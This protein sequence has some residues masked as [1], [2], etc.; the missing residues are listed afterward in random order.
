[1]QQLHEP[2]TAGRLAL[3]SFA[4]T[5]PTD[6]IATIRGRLAAGRHEVLDLVLV[7]DDLGHYQGAIELKQILQARDDSTAEATMRTDWPTVTPNTDQEHAVETASNASVAALPVIAGDGKPLGILPPRVLLDVLAHEHRE[8]VH[9]IV[10]I[11]HEREGATQALEGPPLRR[12]A[13]RL[14]WLLVGLAM[15]AAAVGTMAGFEHVLKANV[16]I[17]FFIPALVYLTDAVGTQTEAIAVR[18]LSL[19][20]I[21][22]GRVLSMEVMTGG[23]IGMALGIIAVVGLWLVFGDLILAIGVGI[24]LFFAATVAS[25]VGLILPWSLSRLDVDP[26]FGSGPVATIV[27]DVLTILIY[28]IVM[29]ALLPAGTG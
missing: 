18:G 23:L 6:T 19:R 15:S 1:V 8:D 16:T 28:F 3:R 11:L 13:G 4:I 14:P 5:S 26:A 22:L 25:A 2:E 9:R 29:I 24:S 21:S 17:A 7:V 12:V 27:Q 20:K 10:G